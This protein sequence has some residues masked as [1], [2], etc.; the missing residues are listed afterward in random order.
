MHNLE[1]YRET[2]GDK[3]ISHIYRM[4]RKLYGKHII[5]LNSTYEGG[6]VAEI[7][8]SLVP[9]MNDT[10]VDVGWRIL[11][12]NPDF[13]NITKKFHNALQGGSIN[14]T[15]RKRDLYVETNRDFSQ[16][17]HIDH[18]CVI[19]HDPQPLPMIQFYKKRQPWVW[20]CH[21]DLTD[22]HDQLWDFLKRFILRYDIIIF[23]SDRYIKKDLPVLQRIIPPAIDP[24][25]LKNKE[26]PEKTIAKYIRKAGIPNDKPVITQVSRMDPWKDPVGLLDV[27][28]HVKKKV[29]CRLVYCYN[30]ASDDPEGWEIY[31]EI[32][33]KAKEL[34]ENRDVIFV[35]GNNDILV[36]AIQRFSTVIVQKSIKEGF[37]LAVT[38][39]LWKG[40]PVVGTNVG[41]IPIQI[42]DEENGFLVEPNDAEGF[43][44]RIVEILK[45]PSLRKKL[46]EK[47]KETVK[48]RFLLT[49]LLMDYLDL[50]NDVME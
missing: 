50:I 4:A 37:C 44:D 2:V 35:M 26:L 10:G 6:G 18:D 43:A 21:I 7:L 33:K 40:K 17:T 22:P 47:G 45:K 36:N 29:D 42:N 23:S 5:N 46:G 25:S 39:A 24:L 30:M 38:E 27:F 41:G 34:S 13:F 3:V 19:I 12:G 11:H 28:Y 1:E 32:S 15:Q 49:R 48:N 16:Y 14:F 9:L 31:A 20:R 8:S